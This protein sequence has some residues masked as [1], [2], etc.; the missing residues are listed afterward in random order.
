[1]TLFF[2]ILDTEKHTLTYC[3][4]GH[5]EPLLIKNGKITK[6]DKG[7]LLLSCFEYSDYDEEEIIFEKGSTLVIFSDGITEAMNEAEEEYGDERLEKI[8][9]DNIKES[10]Q[11]IIKN[12]IT[13]VKLHVG[14]NAQ[15]DD[16]TIMII[17]R[18]G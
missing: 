9:L 16:I 8:L 11:E 7:G 10:S 3:N 17:K 1:V 18:S 12:I 2:G 14:D 5:N 6:L 15:S 4:A 13:D